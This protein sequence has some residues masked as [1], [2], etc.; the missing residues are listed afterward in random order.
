MKPSLT[1]C[2]LLQA[3]MST[4]INRRYASK[5]KVKTFTAVNILPLST[6]TDGT[7]DK[8]PDYETS[9][10]LWSDTIAMVWPFPH[11]VEP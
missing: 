5:V 9:V 1:E 11:I 6:T 4:P 3:I 2:T 8:S 10:D 7:N